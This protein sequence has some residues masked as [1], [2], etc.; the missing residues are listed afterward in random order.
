MGPLAA[1]KGSALWASL[2][3]AVHDDSPIGLSG[4]RSRGPY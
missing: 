1:F 4:F 3:K 2:L